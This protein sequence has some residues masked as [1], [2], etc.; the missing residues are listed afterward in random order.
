M[1]FYLLLR[2]SSTIWRSISVCFYWSLLAQPISLL[3]PW[4]KWKDW[5]AKFGRYQCSLLFSRQLLFFLFQSHDSYMCRWAC[6]VSKLE[7]AISFISLF[8][9]ANHWKRRSFS[10]VR[11][12]CDL[13][14]APDRS[15]DHSFQLVDKQRC[16]DLWHL[17]T[18]SLQLTV[19]ARVCPKHYGHRLY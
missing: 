1:Y 14:Y 5:S 8:S 15:C 2:R 11:H 4:L 17:P 18:E 16:H 7:R 13:F 12:H 3:C 6:F 10:W 19:S 9:Q